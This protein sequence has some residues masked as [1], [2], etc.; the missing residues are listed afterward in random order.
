MLFICYK[1]RKALNTTFSE[2]GWLLAFILVTDQLWSDEIERNLIKTNKWT[3]IWGKDT[4][5]TVKT[6]IFFFIQ[7][8][9]LHFLKKKCLLKLSCYGNIKVNESQRTTPIFSQIISGKFLKFMPFVSTLKMSYSGLKSL[10]ATSPLF[11]VW[12]R[13]IGNE[14]C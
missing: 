10:Q 1:N 11:L 7:E 3:L 13:L 14:W 9:F 12:I 5:I 4:E 2:D 8:S 6:T